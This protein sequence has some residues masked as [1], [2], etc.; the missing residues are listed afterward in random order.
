MFISFNSYSINHGLTFYSFKQLNSTFDAS[1]YL[2]QETL[3]KMRAMEDFLTIV[4]VHV[5]ELVFECAN[6][7][8]S[9]QNDLTSISSAFRKIFDAMDQ[10]IYAV[11]KKPFGFG[12]RWGRA[13][14]ELQVSILFLQ[15]CV[16]DISL[17]LE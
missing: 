5:I 4:L 3:A 10:Y 2:L 15:T 8:L 11:L 6:M 14:N 9:S 16:I 1:I 12:S 13:K 17:V 7:L